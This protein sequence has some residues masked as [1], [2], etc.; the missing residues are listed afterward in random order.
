MVYN[1]AKTINSPEGQ[2]RIG[3]IHVDIEKD[4]VPEKACQDLGGPLH[5]GAERFYREIGVL[6]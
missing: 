4:F 6:Q 3:A 5:P 2:R 1:I